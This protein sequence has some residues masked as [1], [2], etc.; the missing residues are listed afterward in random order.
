MH[1]LW[2]ASWYPNTYEPV[3]GDFI[4]RHA[5]AV[6][7]FIPVTVIHVI[8]L[9]KDIPA[10][11]R[12]ETFTS[13]N[14][15]EIIHYFN[16]KKTGISFADKILYNRRYLQY[17]T[18][19]LLHYQKQHGIP[20]LLH[21]HVPMKAGMMAKKM[22]EEWHIPYVVSEH[23][24][25]YEKTAADNFYSRSRFFRY[26]T[27]RVFKGASIVT[28]VSAT[29]GKKIQK[30]FKLE[31]VV[32]VHNVVDTKIFYYLPKPPSEKFRWLHVSSLAKQKNIEAILHTVK[33]LLPQKIN[34][35]LVIAGPVK[36]QHL[37]LV[38]EQKLKDHI[39]FT[40]EVEYPQVAREM[41]KAD[42]FVLFSNHENFPCVIIEAL[43]CGLPVITSNAGGAA[44]A[45]NE[46]NGIVINKNDTQ[47]L[48]DAMMHIMQNREHYN[49]ADISAKA[50]ALYNE[51]SIAKQFLSL[52]EKVFTPDFQKQV[53]K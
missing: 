29:I 53:G 21:V 39:I 33:S 41:Q 47:G 30:L 26:N 28:N 27:A 22:S 10:E 45:I 5:K 35:E 40:G 3:N 31:E 50:Q 44:E 52:Y 7:Q 51:A 17:F 20:S 48:K 9:G 14:L 11:N 46:N 12:I 16:F 43:C 19:V 1:I 18:G 25:M 49:N 6:A 8:Q 34:W 32:T 37:A 4:Q 36:K 38:N 15:T 2:L 13:G 42:A 24:S 23:A